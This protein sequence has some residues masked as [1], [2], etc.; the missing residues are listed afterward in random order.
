MI[1]D[2]WL[3]TNL[4]IYLPMSFTIP[5]IRI[6]NLFCEFPEAYSLLVKVQ[7]DTLVLQLATW[8]MLDHVTP[9]DRRSG[10]DHV[11]LIWYSAGLVAATLLAA[12]GPT[13]VMV[14]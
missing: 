14:Y 6:I 9:G 8:K 11:T 2:G 13:C 7:L 1:S 5:F 10:D 12:E 4:Y 3:L